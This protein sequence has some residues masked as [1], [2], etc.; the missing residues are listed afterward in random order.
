MPFICVFQ[1]NNGA[2]KET[3]EVIF[4]EFIEASFG[5]FYSLPIKIAKV[6][7]NNIPSFIYSNCPC[8]PSSKGSVQKGDKLNAETKIGYFSA[9]GEDIPY[10]RPYATIGFE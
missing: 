9:D 10:N 6:T 1:L 7:F 4:V 8:F 3:D 5:N 2:I